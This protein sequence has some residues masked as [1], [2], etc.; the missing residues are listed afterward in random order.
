[1]RGHG[2]YQQDGRLIASVAGPVEPVNR[3]VSVRPL[4]TRYNGEV[5]DIVVGRV[6]QVLVQQK[7]WLVDVNARQHAILLLSSINLPGGELRRKTTEDEQMMKSFFTEGDL[8]SAEVQAVY[9]DG[10]LSLHTRSLKYGRL[11]QGQLL[12]VSPSLVERKK[13]HSHDLECGAHVILGNNGYV[14]LAEPSER[15]V[16]SGGFAIKMDEVPIDTRRVLGRLRNCIS[17]L[18][19][20]NLPLYDTSIVECFEA[21]KQYEVRFNDFFSVFF[22]I[23]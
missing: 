5:G 7:R 23:C 13:T 16:Q 4:R 6:V 15:D 20:F 3:L 10:Q 1:M 12:R 18:A 8:I 22:L 14:W 17:I 21:S 2:T 9:T 19:R 11:G